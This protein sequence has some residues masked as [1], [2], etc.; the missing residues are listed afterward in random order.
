MSPSL[1]EPI[2]VGGL[3]VP[4]R[5]YRAPLLE[6]AG[7]GPDAG[8]ALADEL[9]PT[10]AAGCGLVFQGATIVRSEG[11]C[12]APN[13][14]RLHDRESAA[15]L[16]ELPAAVHEAGG[17]VVIQLDHGGLRSLETWHHGYRRAHPELRPLAVSRPPAA[18]RLLDRLGVI[19]LD[20]HVLTTDEVYDLAAD[21]A[22]AA[23][24]AVE[25]G[26]DG[27]HLAGANMGLIQQFCSPYYNRR[28][29]EFGASARFLEVVH[30]AVRERAGDVP[31]V[32]KVPAESGRPPFVRRGL[33]VD[34]GV[35]LAAH[36]AAYGY[37]A[38]VPVETSTFWDASIVRGEF[39]DL[40]WEAPSFQSGYEDAFGGPRRTRLV[41]HLTRLEF[42]RTEFDPAWNAEF[43]RRVR[44]RVDVPVLC[45]GGV[46]GRERM[47]RLL[48]TCCDMV[49]VG[50]PFYA[51]PRLAAR[52]LSDPDA[53]AACRNCNNCV[54]PQAAGA[55]G[56][57]RT[58]DVRRERARRER[59]GEYDRDG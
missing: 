57:C 22:R 35:D 16:R 50:R 29:D 20:A 25:V 32:T 44:E 39:P 26:Y 6:C 12:V 27:V 56:V 8:E 14:T 1:D 46:R 15:R 3:A 34:D 5:L 36:L 10:A 58:P 19:R 4:N 9:A 55:G 33:S 38:V 24:L 59:R 17:R 53:R 37:D 52:L 47:D 7:D 31:L 23:E 41:E 48:G 40:A 51:E 54:V 49:G 42:R 43:C 30:D 13:M 28:D 45:E 21:F 11:G 2:D 18:L